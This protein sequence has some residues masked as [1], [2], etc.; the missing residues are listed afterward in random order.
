MLVLD[1]VTLMHMNFFISLLLAIGLIFMLFERYVCP[2][3]YHWV[4]GMTLMCTGLFFATYR[5]TGGLILSE[6]IASSFKITGLCCI[7]L[8]MEAYC[9]RL[10]TSHYYIFTLTIGLGGVLW[11]M[12]YFQ[13]AELYRV[14][15]YSSVLSLCYLLIVYSSLHNRR[16]F[17]YGR[18]LL[19]IVFIVSTIAVWFRI[20]SLQMLEDFTV[21]DSNMSNLVLL[22]TATFALM[23][24]SFSILLIASQ[25]LQQQLSVFASY[26]ALTGIYNRHGLIEHANLLFQPT[27]G[28]MNDVRSV[29]MIDIDHFK[30]INDRYGHP[31][32]DI[33]L[34]E[35]SLRI[36]RNIRHQD[37]FARYGGEEFVVILPDTNE[38]SALSWI[39]RIR[40]LVSETPVR[41][42]Q[43]DIPVTIS[44]GVAIITP[45][46]ELDLDEAIAKADIALYDAKQTGRNR[47]CCFHFSAI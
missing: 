3:M 28:V 30:Q 26:D 22:F 12:Y 35:V 45:E 1:V 8:G 41:V 20:Y 29:I 10:R 40:S 24:M 13:V 34:K 33:V 47:V 21:L 44:A 36:S 6:F 11:L 19:S 38:V 43:Y 14:S 31:V 27:T 4:I 7:W 15:L 42:N 32:G 18:L 37:V 17:E 25:W 5:M 16:S 46:L 9:E 39:E 23:G 2:G